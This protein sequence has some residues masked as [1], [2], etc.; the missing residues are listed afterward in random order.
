[1]EPRTLLFGYLDPQEAPP[2]CE[3]GSGECSDVEF[4]E[5]LRRQE[6]DLPGPAEVPLKEPLREPLKAPFQ[7]SFKG[8]LKGTPK[9][10]FSG[11]L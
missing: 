9:G 6:S 1:M 3:A 10:A 5:R 7:E 4:A 2:N 8:T 11:V